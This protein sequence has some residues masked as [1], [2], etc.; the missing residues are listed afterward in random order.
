[1]LNYKPK[2]CVTELKHDADDS[3]IALLD[4][5]SKLSK[6]IP[7]ENIYLAQSY[8]EAVSLLNKHDFGVAFVDL[9]MPNKSGMDLIVDVIYKN[10]K[11]RK[12]PVVVTTGVEPDSLI[13]NSLQK[14]TFRYLFK[15][16]SIEELEE[17]LSN[18]PN[19]NDTKQ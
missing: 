11:T 6:L 16:I 19:S 17:S 15:P 4:L 1:M 9:Q 3:K 2:S 18:I 8:F 12:I 5:Q 10:P 7:K 14:L 13:T